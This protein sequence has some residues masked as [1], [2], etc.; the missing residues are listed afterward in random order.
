MVEHKS[1]KN[2]SKE[3]DLKI[4]FEKEMERINPEFKKILK[5]QEEHIREIVE[6]VDKKDQKH[7]MGFFL[8]PLIE[9]VE[10]RAIPNF[11]K[12]SLFFLFDDFEKNIPFFDPKIFFEKDFDKFLVEKKDEKNNE[13]TFFLKKNKNISFR[14]LSISNVRENCFDAIYDELKQIGSSLVYQDR[15]GFISALKTI[16]IHKNMLLQKFEKYIVV[17]AGAGSWLRGEKSNDFDVFIV[18]DDTDVKKMPRLQVKDQLTRLVWQMSAEV[19]QLTGIQLHCQVYLLTDFWD[20]LKDAHPVMFTF[21]RDGVPFY[22]RGIYSAWKELLKLGKIKP[23]AEAIDMHM[24]VGNKLIERA[25]KIFAEVI[26]NDIYNAVLSPSQAILMLKGF[27]PTTPKE[28]VKMFKEV[29]HEKEKCITKSQ[30]DILENTVKM[31]KKIEHE[32]DVDISGKDVDNMIRDAEKYL[33]KIKEM[34]EEISDDK[35]RESILS[36]YSELIN[37]MQTLPG[38]FN[39]KENDIINK[40]VKDFVDSGKIP[41]FV[42]KYLSNFIKTKDELGKRTLTSTEIN[43]SLKQARNILSEIR[44]YRNKLLSSS[45]KKNRLLIKH[46]ENLNAEIISYDGNIFVIDVPNNKIINIENN[47]KEEYS[48]KIFTD[49]TKFSDIEIDEKL[50]VKIKKALKAEKIFF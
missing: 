35:S 16:E 50:I 30:V 23:S 41:P 36:T 40:F 5:K 9:F 24:E 43:Q 13:S 18:V 12:L 28:T 38:L 3:D 15:R 6:F 22:D 34:F 25:K 44:D 32:S 21:L 14:G 27:N 1:K 19:A 2:E 45:V 26:T 20:A 29:L 4:V 10:N 17:Y 37:Q 31:F 8:T 39:L 49:T 33:A 46:G 7:N 42:K 48:E 47:K 11:E